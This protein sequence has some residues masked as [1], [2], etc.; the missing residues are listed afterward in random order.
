MSI[1]VACATGGKSTEPTLTK[2]LAQTGSPIATTCGP[3]ESRPVG[4]GGKGVPA[5][6]DQTGSRLDDAG[7]KPQRPKP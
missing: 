2:R 3:D 4:P 7:P 1:T 5:C 6:L